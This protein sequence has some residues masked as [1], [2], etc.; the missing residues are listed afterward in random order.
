MKII[1]SSDGVLAAQEY[2]VDWVE[3]KG[4]DWLIHT[5]IPTGTEY[6]IL[7]DDSCLALEGI[8]VEQY[9]QV[10]VLGEPDGVSMGQTA[11]EKLHPETAEKEP[12][13]SEYEKDV[14]DFNASTAQE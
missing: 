2:A 3:R 14:E 13:K 1:Y 9:A 5:Y 4:I 12:P 8:P 7:P 6:W 10:L 11:Y